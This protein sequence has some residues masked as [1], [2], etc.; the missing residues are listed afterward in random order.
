MS[1]SLIRRPRRVASVLAV[2]ALCVQALSGIPPADAA[3]IFRT[4]IDL[5]VL[6]GGTFS[7]AYTLND[8]GTV[9]GEAYIFSGDYRAVRWNHDGLATLLP[10]PPGYTN[11]HAIAI[12]NSGEIVGISGSVPLRWDRNGRVTP[13]ETLVGGWSSPQAINDS[14]FAVGYGADSVGHGRAVMWDPDGNITDLG[15]FGGT[16]SSATAING[17]GEVIGSSKTADGDLL[18]VR[19]DRTGRITGLPEIDFPVAINDRGDVLGRN[20]M[21]SPSGRI[22]RLAPLPGSDF[23][24]ANGMN[25]H[26]AVGVSSKIGEKGNTYHA[27]LWPRRTM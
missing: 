14:G 25:E 1:I 4:P 7:T 3:E 16:Y 27:V 8:R 18:T 10:L 22:T 26:A 23:A 5:G 11:C 13:L 20:A 19:W 2:S 15:T 6:P 21:W 12:N 24:I 17:K 9:I